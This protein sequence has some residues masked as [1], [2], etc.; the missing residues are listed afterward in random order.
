[1]PELLLF[2]RRWHAATGEHSRRSD[3]APAALPPLPPPTQQSRLLL[4]APTADALPALMILL[5]LFHVLWF[6]PY[7]TGE[8]VQLHATRGAAVCCRQSA[9]G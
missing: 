4:A 1:M 2:K 9:G 3:Q 5:C 7:A 6:I 8:A